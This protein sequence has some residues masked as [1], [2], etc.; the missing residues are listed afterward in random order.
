[1]KLF[2]VIY[3][4]YFCASLNAQ[5]LISFSYDSCIT[6]HNDNYEIETNLVGSHGSESTLYYKGNKIYYTSGTFGN[7]TIKDIYFLN[8]STGFMLYH[9]GDVSVT[10]AKTNDYGKSWVDIGGGG[11]DV[12][13][14]CILNA[15]NGFLIAHY[16]NI[17]SFSKVSDKGPNFHFSEVPLR[18]TLVYDDIFGETVCPNSPLLVKIK[19]NDGDTINYQFS[20]DQIINLTPTLHKVATS[21]YPNPFQS[22]IYVNNALRNANF[23]IIDISGKIIL[24]GKLN[25]NVIHTNEL[26]SG[27]Y[28]LKISEGMNTK[29]VKIIKH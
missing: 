14:F 21:I 20:F 29:R 8:D 15:N 4:L 2:T 5:S 16:E 12:L 28:I 7:Y 17:V 3:T 23:K 26:S 18:D 25:G 22:E 6:L 19:N 10:I 27:S 1:M 13:G 24:S 11:P 9:N